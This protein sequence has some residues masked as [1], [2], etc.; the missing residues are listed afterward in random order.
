MRK[1]INYN[2]TAPCILYSKTIL[3][4]KQGLFAVA[5]YSNGAKHKSALNKRNKFFNSKQKSVE[6]IKLKKKL[7]GLALQIIEDQLMNL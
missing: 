7:I 1:E 3:L 2:T 6:K 5:D 4:P